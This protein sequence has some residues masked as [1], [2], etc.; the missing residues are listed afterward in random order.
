MIY[1]ILGLYLSFK[2]C[3]YIINHL[4]QKVTLPLPCE[5]NVGQKS[6]NIDRRT[7]FHHIQPYD[8]SWGQNISMTFQAKGQGHRV[9]ELKPFS[10][11]L[12]V[13]GTSFCH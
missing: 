2:K 9:N 10:N 4:E 3:A 13:V 12:L 7:V 11:K 8:Q 1:G 6:T 5:S